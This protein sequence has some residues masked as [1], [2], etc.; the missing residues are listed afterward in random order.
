MHSRWFANANAFSGGIC[1]GFK[2]Y[3]IERLII[4][5][6]LNAHAQRL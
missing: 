1:M 5:T 4:P 2:V 3:G 6:W